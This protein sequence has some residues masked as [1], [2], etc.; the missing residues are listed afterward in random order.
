L[1][2]GPWPITLLECSTGDLQ[3]E[4]CMLYHMAFQCSL[5]DM[6]IALCSLHYAVP[7]CCIAMPFEQRGCKGCI[8][9]STNKVIP[10]IPV[11][12]RHNASHTGGFVSDTQSR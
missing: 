12:W 4:R 10:S 3:C 6:Q 7:Q 2:Y 9:L 8:F 5:S 11:V 1:K